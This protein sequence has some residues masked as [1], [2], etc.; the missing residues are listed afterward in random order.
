MPSNSGGVESPIITALWPARSAV[1]RST[2]AISSRYC[3]F[4]VMM[5]VAGGKTKNEARYLGWLTP[6]P[7]QPGYGFGA[8]FGSVRQNL[9]G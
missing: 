7:N 8:P 4:V 6:E 2:I 5:C 3:R 9:Q 1:E